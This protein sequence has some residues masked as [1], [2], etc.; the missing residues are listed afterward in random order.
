MVMALTAAGPA[1][2]PR[3][4]ISRQPPRNCTRASAG[5]ASA[6]RVITRPAPM[7]LPEPE[8]DGGRGQRPEGVG[9]AAAGPSRSPRITM[10]GSA[11]H[12]RPYRSMT[13]PAG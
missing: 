1:A 10:L 3:S 13:P 11:T 4:A 2:L 8:D 12:I 5:E 9:E 7:P 6:P